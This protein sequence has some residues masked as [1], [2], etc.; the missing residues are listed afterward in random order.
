MSLKRAGLLVV[1]LFISLRLSTWALIGNCTALAP[2][3]QGYVD[4]FNYVQ[5]PIGPRPTLQWPHTPI[6]LLKVFFLPASIFKSMGF[7]DLS[8][9]RAQSIILTILV[10]ILLMTA[11]KVFGIREKF[12]L[13]S[14]QGRL[15]LV[16]FWLLAAC[17]PTVILWS[18]LG[19]REVYLYLSITLIFLSIANIFVNNSRAYFL[20]LINLAFSLFILGNT[21]FYIF[22]I[23]QLSIL[24]VLVLNVLN[25]KKLKKSLVVFFLLIVS[26]IPFNQQISDINFPQISISSFDFNFNFLDS[27]SAPRLPS[28]TYLELRTC[29]ANKTAGPLLLV[30]LRAIDSLLPQRLE[31][32]ESQPLVGAPAATALRADDL[33][34]NE[35]NLLTLPTG[36]LYFL[37]FP[38]S[39][40]SSGIFG[41]LGLIEIIFWLPLYFTFA[42]QVYRAR[43]KLQTDTFACL[44]LAFVVLFSLF[45]ALAEVNFGTAIRHRSLLIIPILLLG[46]HLWTEKKRPA[47][48]PES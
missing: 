5:N 42:V 40:I 2:D 24:I 46:T 1:G 23:L 10:G 31:K 36:L 33:L 15:K 41:I 35:F 26:L 34:R 25:K 4:M 37:F 19:L 3:E 47:N 39:V 16:I 13:L 17:T 27:N 11:F 22:I 29:V 7:S 9:F 30:S 32:V 45:S 12:D 18:I 28:T 6:I 48:H 20:W 44:A 14:K 8:A 21:K 38:I 43:S